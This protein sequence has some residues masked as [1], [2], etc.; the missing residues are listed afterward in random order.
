MNVRE[1]PTIASSV[2]E[3][4]EH[5]IVI[6]VG[7]TIIRLHGAFNDIARTGKNAT[8]KYINSI[9]RT[10]MTSFESGQKTDNRTVSASYT[11]V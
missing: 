11:A 1:K 5:D 9:Q 6:A 3:G 8:L 2:R 7:A 4:D 10:Y